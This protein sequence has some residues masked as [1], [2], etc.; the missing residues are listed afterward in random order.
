MAY[1]KK[2]KLSI[3]NLKKIVIDIKTVF[4]FEKEN[5]VS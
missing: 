1:A 2:S 5:Y 3:T 4:P